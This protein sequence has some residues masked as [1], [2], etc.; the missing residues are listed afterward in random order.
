MKSRVLPA[1]F[2]VFLAQP[3]DWCFAISKDEAHNAINTLLQNPNSPAARTAGRVVLEFAEA[4]PNHRVL[5]NLGY[6]PWAKNSGLPDGSQMLLAAFVAG[7]LQE[8][9]KKKSST[10]EP[11]AGALAVIQVYQKMS[12]SNPRFKITKVEEFIAM[13]KRGTLRAHINSIK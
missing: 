9:M 7:N 10:P 13:E 5:I 1:L 12:R 3:C 8:Q 4:T 6:L 11:Y 2:A